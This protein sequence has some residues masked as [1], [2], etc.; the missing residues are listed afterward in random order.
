VGAVSGVPSYICVILES[1]GS[2]GGNHAFCR[3]LLRICLWDLLESFVGFP[4]YCV[5]GCLDMLELTDLDLVGELWDCWLYKE[6][7]LGG[8][9]LLV[10]YWCSVCL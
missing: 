4:L 9:S 10:C 3:I 8:V 2:V 1:G 6:L 5:V 7:D